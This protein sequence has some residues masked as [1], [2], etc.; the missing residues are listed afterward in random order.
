MEPDIRICIFTPGNSS[1]MMNYRPGG[2]WKH[3]AEGAFTG[4]CMRASSSI[5]LHH[6]RQAAYPRHTNFLCCSMPVSS[7][8]SISWPDAECLGVLKAG[9]STTLPE[10]LDRFFQRTAYGLLSRRT[11]WSPR[12]TSP[13]PPF[14]PFAPAANF[15]SAE[16]L[17]RPY[18]PSGAFLHRDVLAKEDT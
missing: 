17:S 12:T 14:P 11:C 8:R 10:F 3:P 15:L 5:V 13:V 2:V 7:A 6:D 16:L 4:S 9:L 1:V 18:A